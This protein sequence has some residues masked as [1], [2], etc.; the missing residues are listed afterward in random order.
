MTTDLFRAFFALDLRGRLLDADVPH[1][2]ML[3]VEMLELGVDGCKGV[4]LEETQ[5]DRW[6]SDRTDS[7]DRVELSALL[8]ARGRTGNECG[9]GQ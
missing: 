9:S 1:A 8:R 4:L 3:E 2:G 5:S 7:G 6:T